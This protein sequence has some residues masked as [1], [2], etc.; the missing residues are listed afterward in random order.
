M[1]YSTFYLYSLLTWNYLKLSVIAFASMTHELIFALQN[2]QLEK[3]FSS[4]IDGKEQ[5]SDET[6]R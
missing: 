2:E 5:L 1:C 6:L 4:L 3:T